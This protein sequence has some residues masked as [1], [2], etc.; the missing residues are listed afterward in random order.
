MDEI[1]PSSLNK[2][3]LHC[4]L[5]TTIY[6][7]QCM[8][9]NKPSKST[10]SIGKKKKMRTL[11]IQDAFSC[12]EIRAKACYIK[13]VIRNAARKINLGRTETR[14]RMAIDGLKEIQ[15]GNQESQ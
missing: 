9:T 14:E 11:K 7:L 1:Q 15:N 4:A 6:G 2:K 12:I 8:V 5:A 3:V 13:D 10:E